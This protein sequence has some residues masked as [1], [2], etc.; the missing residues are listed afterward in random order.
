MRPSSPRY[1]ANRATVFL[2]ILGTLAILYQLVAH[3]PA[4]TS[5]IGSALQHA[6]PSAASSNFCTKEIGEGV[7]CELFLG[8]EPCAD[9]CRKE[10]V[11]RETFTL[12]KEYD[13]C[14]DQCLVMY[15]ST[16]GE[17][18]GKTDDHAEEREPTVLKGMDTATP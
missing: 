2:V 18:E 10:Y 17:A 12:T 3:F 6:L 11:D 9:E 15:K 7:C 1:S 13:E 8:A 16:C 4:V 5:N 14:A